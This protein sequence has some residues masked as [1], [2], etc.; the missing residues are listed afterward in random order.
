M[1]RRHLVQL[2]ALGAVLGGCKSTEVGT[3]RIIV[4]PG[5][6]ISFATLDRTR[7]LNV[8]IVTDEGDTVT[9]RAFRWSS[10]NASVATVPE[11][12]SSVTV[13]ARRN[14]TAIL[15][16]TA[17]S[18]RKEIA[19]TVA[20]VAASL[21]KVSGDRQYGTELQLLGQPVVVFA[22]DSAGFLVSGAPVAFL[23][24]AGGSVVPA[25][26][27]TGPDGLASVLWRLGSGGTHRLSATTGGAPAVE[28]SATSLP[29]PAPGFQITL[30]NIGGGAFS[31][32]VQAAFNAAT[33]YWQGAIS[34]DL[35]DVAGFSMQSGSCGSGSPA[36][37]VTV[38]DVMILANVGPIDGPGGILG[39]AGPCFYRLGNTSVEQPLVGVM[40]FDSDDIGGLAATGRLDA[41]IRHEM[42][43]VLGF[44]PLWPA[45]VGPSAG[46]GCLQNPSSPGLAQDTHYSCARGVAVFD[47]IGGTSYTGG[48]R[49]PVENCAGIPGCGAGTYN[50]HWRESTFF[51]ELMTGYLNSG[52]ANPVSALTLAALSDLGYTVNLSAAEAYSRVFMAPPAVLAPSPPLDLRDDTYRG[53]VHGVI[54]R[55]GIMRGTVPLR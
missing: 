29:A 47:S 19:V 12:G 16:V 41:V 54:A 21:A 9:D 39:G 36:M 28:F 35:G 2:A 24:T 55:R 40:Q 7:L 4:S 22:R 42:A 48:S 49:V 37:N 13:T 25:Q 45:V 11:S 18:L 52:T 46:F 3:A 44:G 50:S 38:D 8:A 20:Q 27:T 1:L 17:G 33:A 10:S 26:A 5:S 15:T 31:A 34:G 51:N 30:V 43:H 32:V 53:P 6:T 23:A 14:G